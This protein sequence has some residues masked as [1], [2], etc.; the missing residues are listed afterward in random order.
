MTEKTTYGEGAG[1]TGASG[2]GREQNEPDEKE[3]ARRAADEIKTAA[4]EAA[5]STAG[6]VRN[7]LSG[8][9]DFRKYKSRQRLSRVATA[10]RDAG[11]NFSTEDEAVAHYMGR[12]A[13]RVEGIAEYLDQRD[14]NEILHDAREMA[15]RRPEI[16]VGTLFVAGLML[17]R[18][19]RSSA[20][21]GGTHSTAR[22][23]FSRSYSGVG[24]TG[25][26]TGTGAS[27]VSSPTGGLVP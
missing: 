20:P 26:Y 21:N 10:L 11:T 22:G 16:F 9:L 15:R 8:E 14:V 12:A 3:R 19:L 25:S 13:D 17:G 1:S 27:P 23:D 5:V 2:Y 6:A 7:R 4:K 24:T 18:F